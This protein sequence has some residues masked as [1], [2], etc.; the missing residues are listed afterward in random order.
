MDW[1]QWLLLIYWIGVPVSG[2]LNWFMLFG[3]GGYVTYPSVI[4]RNAFLWP[5]MLPIVFGMFL[6]S[7]D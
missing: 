1:W 5:V 4:V 6:Q 2:F 7:R 3:S